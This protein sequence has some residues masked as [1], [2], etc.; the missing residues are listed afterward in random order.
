MN[1]DIQEANVYKERGNAIMGGVALANMNNEQFEKA[2]PEFRKALEYN[3]DDVD[4]RVSLAMCLGHKDK[5]NEIILL[6]EEVIQLDP[7]NTAHAHLGRIYDSQERYTEAAHEYK[8]AL[9]VFKKA[10]DPKLGPLQEMAGDVITNVMLGR[11]VAEADWSDIKTRLAE[12]DKMLKGKSDS[13]SK[14]EE[15]RWVGF[16]Q[17]TDYQSVGIRFAATLI[18]GIIIFIGMM[19][20]SGI[21]SF[22]EMKPIEEMSMLAQSSIY[23]FFPLTYYTILEGVKGATLGKKICGIHVEKVDGTPCDIPSSIVRN[24]LRFIDGFFGYFIGAIIIWNSD[25]KQRLGD[26]VAKTVV[27]NNKISFGN[28]EEVSTQLVNKQVSIMADPDYDDE[29]GH[30]ED[31]DIM[32][33]VLELIER[34]NIYQDST[35][36]NEII[37]ALKKSSFNFL[38]RIESKPSCGVAHLG[39]GLLAKILNDWDDAIK[40][41]ELALQD[42]SHGCYPAYSEPAQLFLNDARQKKEHCSVKQS[43]DAQIIYRMFKMAYDKEKKEKVLPEKIIQKSFSERDNMGT[44]QD[45]MDHAVVYWMARNTGQKFE[46]YVLYEFDEGSDAKEALLELDCI[47]IAED[48]GK[49]ICTETLVFGYYQRDDGKWEAIVCGE[50]MNHELWDAAKNSFVNNG[51]QRKNDQEPE[52]RASTTS[53]SEIAEPDEVIFVREDHKQ[54][55]EEDTVYRIHKGPDAASA[56]AFFEQNPVDRKFYHIVIETP[57]GNYCRDIQGIYKE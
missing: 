52:E 6:L 28:Q 18:D 21:Y 5:I 48:T 51:G 55:M 40:E 46:P 45:T 10:H 34:V 19:I 41:F 25:K 27:V 4:A 32:F 3:P 47:H 17:N 42:D 57:E 22:V 13:I 16:G 44:R 12:I 7:N 23:I 35:N 54:V 50:D 53:E 31:E 33:E 56:K 26:M 1:K 20:L 9:R 37:Q 38:E 29:D 8:E 11:P 15:L 49:L 36:D 2:E 24:L 14:K 39:L 43:I 30:L